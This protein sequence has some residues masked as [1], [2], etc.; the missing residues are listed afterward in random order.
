MKVMNDLKEFATV[1]RIPYAAL[2]IGLLALLWS[3]LQRMVQFQDLNTG[4]LDP[5]IWLLILLS[6]GVFLAL[7]ALVWHLA[8]YYWVAYGLPERNWMV[9]QF[10]RLDAWQQ[11]KFYYGVFALLLLAVIGCL[12]AVL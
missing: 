4:F 11:L 5:T 6:I 8:N 12:T 1:G 10:N 2:L 7:L 3:P 9:L